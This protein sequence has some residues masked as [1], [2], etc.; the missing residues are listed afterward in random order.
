M[1][2][3]GV[4]VRRDLVYATVGGLDLCLDVYLPEGPRPGF[5]SSPPPSPSFEARLLGVE[6]VDQAKAEARAAS[7]IAHVHP[8]APPFLLMHG[9]RDG[10]IPSVHSRSLAQAL[11]AEGVDASLMLLSGAN[12]ED[13]AFDSPA[14]LGAVSGFLRAVL[15][16]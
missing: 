11:R 6:S 15:L 14:S 1:A 13:P 5:L 9:D 12:H 16:R 4:T 10:L 8:A 7:P 2:E 3:S